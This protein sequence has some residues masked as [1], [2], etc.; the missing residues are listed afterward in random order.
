MLRHKSS[1]ALLF[2]LLIL[3]SG[4]FSWRR[5][6]RVYG[7]RDVPV[8]SK[9]YSIEKRPSIDCK[10]QGSYILKDGKIIPD[11]D[12]TEGI[13]SIECN[14][15]YCRSYIHED[16]GSICWKCRIDSEIFIELNDGNSDRLSCLEKSF[17][18]SRDETLFDEM[19]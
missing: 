19:D 11:R 8:N 7:K 5:R 16:R 2:L 17:T 18:T 10:E 9:R 1:F 6:R 13:A 4:V 14:N 3:V 15:D 12:T